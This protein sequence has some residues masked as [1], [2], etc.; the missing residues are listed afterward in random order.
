MHAKHWLATA[1][2]AVLLGAATAMAAHAAPAG[3]ATGDLRTTAREGTA[4][5][6]AHYYRRRWHRHRHRHFGFYLGA[7]YWGYYPRHYYHRHYYRP[8]LHF[9]FGPR[10]HRHWHRHRHWW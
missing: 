6:P 4:I 10:R 8:G 5:E 2:A 3:S 9:Y 7:P 1:A